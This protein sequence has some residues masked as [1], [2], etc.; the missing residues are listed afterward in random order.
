MR[1]GFYGDSFCSDLYSDTES[2]TYI[3]KTIDY[4]NADLISL[5]VGGSSVWDVILLQFPKDLSTVP[6]VCIFTW[7]SPDRLFHRT[8]R[9]ITHQFHKST[10]K[11]TELKNAVEQYFI[12]LHDQEKSVME[13]VSAMHFFDNKILSQ[14]NSKIIHLWSF[15]NSYGEAGVELAGAGYEF[16]N[17]VDTKLNLSTLATLDTVYPNHISS[18][19]NNQ[20]IFETIK[21][22]I[23]NY[24]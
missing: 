18:D 23:N 15:G 20:L 9:K 12:H 14:V 4:Y 8:V 13:A 22:A 10:S 24:K 2:E 7:T 5:G 6:D 16:T 11:D 17:G 1:I 3:K 19:K 21:Q